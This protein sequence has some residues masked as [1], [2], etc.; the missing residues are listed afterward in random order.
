MGDVRVLVQ[1]LSLS[2]GLS[3]NFWSALLNGPQIRLPYSKC[4]QT[5]VLYRRGSVFVSIQKKSLYPDECQ[6][7]VPL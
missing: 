2:S 6:H 4:G 3:T 5:R 1:A 7:L